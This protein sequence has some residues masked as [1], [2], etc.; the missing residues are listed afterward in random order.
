MAGAAG[1]TAA[2]P[3]PVNPGPAGLAGAAGT[4][5]GARALLSVRSALVLTVS[6]LA[7][8]GG[9]ALLYTA[10]RPAA[11][12][13]LGAVGIFAGALKLLDSLIELAADDPGC[14]SREFCSAA[15]LASRP[16]MNPRGQ[17]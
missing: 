1:T 7:A 2:R 13:V 14:H 16:V 11:L 12:I 4:R 8:L 17:A 15:D 9:A 5:P 6:V 10:H 3:V